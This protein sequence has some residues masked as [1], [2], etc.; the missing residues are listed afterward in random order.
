[1]LLGGYTLK[2]MK[3]FR[4]HGITMFIAVVLHT[5]TIL[6]V[7]IP[8]FVLGFS[9][10]SSLDLTNIIVIIA[11]VHASIGISV[12]LLGV[13]IVA[14]WRLRTSL[15]TCFAKKKVMLVTLTLWLI[16][17]SLGILL[18]LNFYTTLLHL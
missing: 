16:A 18:Y 17:I 10:P 2:R 5:I 6:T 13:W 3:K 9:P 7:M 11:L 4:Q 12:E 1:L 8:S 14:S 15:Q